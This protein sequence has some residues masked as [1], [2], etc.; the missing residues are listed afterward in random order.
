MIDSK[1]AS[2]LTFT[3]Y[4]VIGHII[5]GSLL[6]LFIYSIEITQLQLPSELIFTGFI[7]GGYTLGQTLSIIGNFLF[8]T[9]ISA[10]EY[11]MSSFR[12]HSIIV[13]ERSILLLLLKSKKDG[14]L[15]VKND[16][17]KLAEKNLKLKNLSNRALFQLCDGLVASEGFTERDTL[18][19]R[20]EFYRALVGFTILGAL[21]VVYKGGFGYSYILWLVIFVLALRALLYIHDYYGQ[22]RKKQIYLLGLL[23]LREMR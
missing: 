16:L 3:F 20:Q 1:F 6:L 22:I 15:D 21:Y 4:D 7:I 13:I 2:S 18:L 9:Y 17:R 14:G 5:P 19:A 12:Y 10:E 8:H 23:K 11:P